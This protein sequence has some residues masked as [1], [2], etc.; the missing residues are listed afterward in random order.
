MDRKSVYVLG[1][2]AGRDAGRRP[3]RWAA[4]EIENLADEAQ[5]DLRLGA[6]VERR[7]RRQEPH[8]FVCQ[9][10]STLAHLWARWLFNAERPVGVHDTGTVFHG[11]FDEARRRAVT[12]S[13]RAPFPRRV[14]A[15]DGM[16]RTGAAESRT[17]MVKAT[18]L[19]CTAAALGTPAASGPW[20][21]TLLALVGWALLS[22]W[23]VTVVTPLLRLASATTDGGQ[24][25]DKGANSRRRRLGYGWLAAL[26]DSGPLFA[27]TVWE[28]QV[29]GPRPLCSGTSSWSACCSSRAA[30]GAWPVRAAGDR[31]K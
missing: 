5:L 29:V 7:Q 18:A 11:S 19:S 15:Y 21:A 25:P 17:W 27:V 30:S 1:M 28:A 12:G 20:W 16:H 3:E 24:I 22:W 26:T 31:S 8:W 13:V 2:P 14:G 9:P 6:S 23:C 10:R 4:R